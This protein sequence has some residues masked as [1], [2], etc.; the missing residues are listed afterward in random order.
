[1]SEEIKEVLPPK[2]G[3]FKKLRESVDTPEEK[4]ELLSTFV[5]LG[6]LIWSGAI[7]TLA[8]IKMPPVLGIPEQKLDPTFIASV[9]TGTLAT[10]GV[11]AA[12]DKK[13]NNSGLTKEDIE[14]MIAQ[15]DSSTIK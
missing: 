2:K 8:Y 7:L 6:I 3:P 15:K 11:Q 12:K 10:F 9:F 14:K 13:S 1:M 4:V 5:R